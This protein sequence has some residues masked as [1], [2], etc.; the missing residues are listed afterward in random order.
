[1]R[2]MGFRD[3]ATRPL[4][5][6]YEDRLLAGLDRTKLPHHIGVIHDGHRRYAR[7][8]GLPDYASSYQIRMNKFIDF[9][10]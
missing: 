6:I 2:R 10:H 5:R 3:L 7:S 1:M 9:L 4:Y 8:E